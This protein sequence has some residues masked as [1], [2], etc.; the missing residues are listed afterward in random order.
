MTPAP[1]LRVLSLTELKNTGIS[2]FLLGKGQG[3]LGSALSV[4]HP[5]PPRRGPHTGL[6]A[7]PLVLSPLC[8]QQPVLLSNGASC[9][10]TSCPIP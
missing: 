2:P 1:R 5:H 6:P 10:H 4:H 9:P 7:A 3:I 8:S